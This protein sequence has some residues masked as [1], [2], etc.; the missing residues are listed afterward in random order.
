MVYFD[1]EHNTSK[2]LVNKILVAIIK[3]AENQSVFLIYFP[4][5]SI[6]QTLAKI[7]HLF[8]VIFLS[9]SLAAIMAYSI[10]YSHFDASVKT[11]IENEWNEKSYQQMCW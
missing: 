1:A 8:F 10:H 11:I 4:F 5:S 3:K 6:G 7:I 2:H 9:M